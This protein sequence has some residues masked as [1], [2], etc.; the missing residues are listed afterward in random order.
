M[1]G[2][3]I[4]RGS[5]LVCLGTTSLYGVRPSQYDR[6][7]VPV[8]TATA[9]PSA[10]GAGEKP[11]EGGTPTGDGTRSVPTTLRWEYLGKTEGIGTVQFGG[12]TVRAIESLLVQSKNGQRVNSVFGEGSN[13]RL[14]KLRDAFGEM[15]LDADEFLRHGTP[16]LVYGVKLAENVRDYLLGLD[17]RP[18][19]IGGSGKGAGGGD[20]AAIVEW[21]RERW[22]RKRIERGDVLERIERETLV[23]PVRHA[24]RV[25][26]PRD[27]GQGVLFE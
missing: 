14:R 22:V 21:W 5:E 2:R 17:K 25:V 6:I 15:G 9:E 19:W 27:V 23:R 4:V 10:W 1:A 20:A 16:R 11:P 24:A 7:A 13:P 18:R 8:G 26:L 3:R 12:A